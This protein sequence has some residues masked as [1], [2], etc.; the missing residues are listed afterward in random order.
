MYF[1]RTTTLNFAATDANLPKNIL[2]YS[3]IG[4]PTGASINPTTGLFTWTPSVGQAGKFYSFSIRVQDNGTP[5][6]SDQ[7]IASCTVQYPAE[8]SVNPSSP[9]LKA[10]GLIK[11]E[12]PPEKWPDR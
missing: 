3:L 6:K 10:D 1:G 4:A 11:T 5:S 8:L 9:S 2:S 12:L 7:Q